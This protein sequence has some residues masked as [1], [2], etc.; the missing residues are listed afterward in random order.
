MTNQELRRSLLDLV[1]GREKLSKRDLDELESVVGTT[2][3]FLTQER[4]ARDARSV[5]D[6]IEGAPV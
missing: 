5:D 4:R 1:D 6:C 3:Y 2:A